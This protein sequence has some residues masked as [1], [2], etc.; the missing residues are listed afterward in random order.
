M[1]YNNWK[2]SFHKFKWNTLVWNKF[3]IYNDNNI[4]Y[5]IIFTVFYYYLKELLTI[6][7]WSTQFI[8]NL[9]YYKIYNN[10]KWIIFNLYIHLFVQLLN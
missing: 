10:S 8:L 1:L 9:Y 5:Y 4:L 6:Y 7:S 3:I 2:L